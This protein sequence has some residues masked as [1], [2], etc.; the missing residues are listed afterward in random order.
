MQ[1]KVKQHSRGTEILLAEFT[2][3]A[4]AKLFIKGKLEEDAEQ[5]I[6]ATYRLVEFDEVIEEFDKSKLGTSSTTV[7]STTTGSQ[8]KQAS[9]RPTPL[10]TTPRPP[11]TPP[12]WIKDDE[13][14][15]KK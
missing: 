10:A 11:G 14:E 15:G 4:N 12:K 2:N 9:F 3:S 13:E 8:G 6:D 1:Y 7:A 5:K